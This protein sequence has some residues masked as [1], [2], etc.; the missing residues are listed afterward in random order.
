MIQPLRELSPPWPL[1]LFRRLALSR[2]LFCAGSCSRW[3]LSI[4]VAF[5][6]VL[7]FKSEMDPRVCSG[8]LCLGI[9][10]LLWSGGLDTFL[11]FQRRIWWSLQGCVGNLHFVRFNHCSLDYLHSDASFLPRQYLIMYCDKLN[12]IYYAI[13][14]SHNLNCN[15]QSFKEKLHEISM[16]NLKEKKFGQVS[17]LR[18][19]I[20][21]YQF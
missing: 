8:I 15:F 16:K 12:S 21:V 10:L 3:T 2:W 17:F 18:T 5:A 20:I 11:S 1:S 9:L 7:D 19:T 13:N 4:C 6:I 14:M